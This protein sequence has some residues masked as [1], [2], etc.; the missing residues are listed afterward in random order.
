MPRVG[1]T[2]D[3]QSTGGSQFEFSE[4]KGRVVAAVV[5]NHAIPGLA[6]LC[7]YKLTIQRLGEDWKPTSDEPQDEFLSA[8]FCQTFTGEPGFHPGNAKSSDDRSPELEIGMAGDMGDEDGAEG[9]CLLSGTGYGPM[10]E[11]GKVPAQLS[12]FTNSCVE[13]GVKKELFNGFAPNLIGLEAQFTRMMMKKSPTSTAKREPTCLIIG[14]GGKVAGGE[15]HKYPGGTVAGAAGKA[16]AGKPAGAGAS[17]AGR[18]ANG[19]AGGPVAVPAEAQALAGTGDGTGDGGV[20]EEVGL[21]AGELLRSMFP[22]GTGE[23]TITRARLQNKIVTLFAKHR[24]PANMHKPIQD[25][26]KDDQWF[27]EFAEDMDWGVVGGTITIP[28]VEAQ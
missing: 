10:G 25:A 15:V 4:G 28:A 17:T 19:V 21:K 7:G 14:K 11:N 1:S 2:V 22:A 27:G 3:E 12:I 8:G 13:H 26:I 18:K 24:V 6:T 16:A 9:T 23:Q 20:T 5:A